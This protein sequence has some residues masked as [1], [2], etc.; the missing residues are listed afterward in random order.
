M[1]YNGNQL[2][3]KKDINGEV[4]EI[5]ICTSNRSA[6]KTTF[7]S[8][9]VIENFKK[10]NMNKFMILYR[11]KYELDSCADKFFKDIKNIYYTKN[12]MTSKKA[13]N[14]L[15]H[16][17]F[18]DGDL[19]GYAIPINSA[20][21]LKKYSHFF[22]DTTIMLLDEFQSETNTY[23]PNE[24]NKLISIHTS[25]ARGNGEM[26]RRVPLI[27]IGNPVSIINP[28]YTALG[29]SDRLKKDT[30][31]L[32]GNGWVLEQGFNEEANNAQSVSPFNR[33]FMNETYTAYASQG[34]YLNDNETFIDK[35]TGKNN[36]LCTLKYKDICYGIREYPEEGVIYCDK[37][38]DNSYKF[39]IC[40]TTNDHEINY[41]MLHSHDLFLQNLRFY[42]DKGC[43]RFKDLQ[44]KEAVLKTLSY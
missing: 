33:A 34:V 28:Y 16:N 2:L 42:F 43:F 23:V 8:H 39:K 20:D 22:S 25:V 36:Y 27:L 37:N 41:V 35:L 24:V 21:A 3:N 9:Y 17:L 10:N 14:G 44:C 5:Y 1:Y 12:I 6:G 30:R 11:Y 40:T 38:A 26:V 7:F 19:C 29:V 15:F 13:A 32:R 4:P 31:F 18:L